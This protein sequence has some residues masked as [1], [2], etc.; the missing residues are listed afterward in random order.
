VILI[1]EIRDE[2]CYP[3]P[4]TQARL[5]RAKEAYE[6]FRKLLCEPTS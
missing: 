5:E 3:S 1:G 4:I 2:V 6:A